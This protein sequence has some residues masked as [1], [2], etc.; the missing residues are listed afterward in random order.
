[1]AKI[2]D[3]QAIDLITFS[4]AEAKV[5]D[6]KYSHLDA[7]TFAGEHLGTWML[8]NGQSCAGTAFQVMTGQ[9]T[10]PDAVT[11][12]EFLRQAKSGRTVGSAEADAFQGH[13]H[14]STAQVLTNINEGSYAEGS[15]RALRT[16]QQ[17]QTGYTNDGSLGSPRVA[18]E[19]RPKNIALNLYVKVGY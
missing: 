14:T 19:T 12:G 10:V 2:Q 11:N 6:Y 5:G 15:S 3:G 18:D 16:L 7:A 4:K 8:C 1:M 17:L 13:K 9:A